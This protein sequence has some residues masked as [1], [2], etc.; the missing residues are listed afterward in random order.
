M[1]RPDV[2]IIMTD[3]ERAAPPYE[4]DQVAAWR[5]T[6][7]TGRPRCDEHAVNFTRH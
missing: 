4:P 1:T 6:T 3:E 2:V 7:L 5:R